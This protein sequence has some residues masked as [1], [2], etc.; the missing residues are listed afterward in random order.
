[1]FD[2][3]CGVRLRAFRS[4]PTETDLESILSLYNDPRV[5]PLISEYFVIPRGQKLKDEFKELIEKTAEMFCII[6]TIPPLQSEST[7]ASV[8]LSQFMGITGLWGRQERG[9]RHV[10]YS[11]VLVP[12]FWDK[13][14]GTAITKFMVDYAFHHLNMHRV[15]LEVYEGNDR[16]A[17]VYRKYGF[18][19]EG[20]QRQAR[21]ING[22]WKDIIHMGILV[23]EWK[24][25]KKEN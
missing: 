1:M 19:D 5:A 24:K 9:H 8:S 21:W 23:D 7:P 20:R 16:A 18:V 14:F 12:E 10:N 11:I 15:S 25:L 2:L 4:S 13:G 17:A 22:E 6:E 3:N